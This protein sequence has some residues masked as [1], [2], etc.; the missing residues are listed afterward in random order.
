M[1]TISD[2][3][4]KATTKIDENLFIHKK[5]QD[6][7]FQKN[8]SLD[9][10]TN[11]CSNI[12][13]STYCNNGGT[14]SERDFDNDSIGYNNTERDY[15]KKSISSNCSNNN[16]TKR[17]NLRNSFQHQF[18]DRDSFGKGST[19]TLERDLEIIDLLERERSMDIQEMI[20]KERQL[21][22]VS[23]QGSLL[24]RR[25]KLPEIS[26]F[27]PTLKDDLN[28]LSR[29]NSRTSHSTKRDSINSGHQVEV[30]DPRIICLEQ[31]FNRSRGSASSKGSNKSKEHRFSIDNDYY[32]DEL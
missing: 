18:S 21:T 19:S 29:K 28:N 2:F 8:Y 17:H 27:S 5:I 7:F 11:S 25:R 12:T 23:R 6:N 26:N 31:R 15:Y 4:K 30:Q 9:P 16:N 32:G 3:K 20:E 1:N 24:D 22:S 14:P 13:S 10:L